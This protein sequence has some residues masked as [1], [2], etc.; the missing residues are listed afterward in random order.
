MDI[1]ILLESMMQHTLE[2]KT[3][4]Y[5]GIPPSATD[6]N[7]DSKENNIPAGLS[8][9]QSL[10]VPP[11]FKVEA[12]LATHIAGDPLAETEEA[13]PPPRMPMTPLTT[14]TTEPMVLEP[15]EKRVMDTLA[16]GP[17]AMTIAVVRLSQGQ[18]G[19]AIGSPTISLPA[20]DT[21]P[22]AV[23]SKGA[24]FILG[25]STI[26]A[27]T[28]EVTVGSLVL[29]MAGPALITKG[30][31]ISYVPSGI[32]IGESGKTMTVPFSKIPIADSTSLTSGTRFLSALPVIGSGTRSNTDPTGTTNSKMFRI[33]SVGV[34]IKGKSQAT[35]RPPSRFTSHITSAAASGSPSQSNSRV[36]STSSSKSEAATVLRVVHWVYLF[37]LLIFSSAILLL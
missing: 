9:I 34:N 10:A 7:V 24:I 17:S 5:G 15:S 3:T 32:I 30:R 25:S 31:T 22:D 37:L 6:K 36:L 14:I 16:P 13:S 18:G 11:H 33:S 23:S 20:A 1:G 2:P 4:I 21:V 27:G 26:T 19:I 35:T 8:A 29:S 28:A 12:Q